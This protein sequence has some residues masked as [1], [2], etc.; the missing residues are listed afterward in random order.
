MFFV[1]ISKVRNADAD[2]FSKWCL[3]QKN[4]QFFCEISNTPNQHGQIFCRA[5]SN[6]YILKTG[7]IEIRHT[8]QYILKTKNTK[9][10]C[11]HHTEHQAS[12]LKGQ[13]RVLQ[14]IFPMRITVFRANSKYR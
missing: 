5:I 1:G 6:N 13:A 11:P 9:S 14:P 2:G 7:Q 3:F 8:V 10:D 12:K 4:W